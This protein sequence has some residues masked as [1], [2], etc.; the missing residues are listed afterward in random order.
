MILLF[1]ACTS[2]KPGARDSL[3]A[4]DSAPTE[5]TGAVDTAITG[6]DEA[7][8]LYDRS[9]LHEISI[10]LADADWAELRAQSRSYYSLLGE[11]CGE[12]PW[13]SPY[14]WFLGEV[15]V[16]GTDLGTVGVRKK[17]LIGS[18]SSERPSLKIDVDHEVDDARYLG[19][20]KLTLNNNNQDPGRLRTCLAHDLF[21]DAGLVAPRCSLAH[22]TVNGEDL[23]VYSNTENID[24]DLVARRRGALPSAMYEGALSDFREDWLVTFEAET[25]ESDGH[26]LVP[27][28]EALEAPD[29]ELLARLDEVIDLE[30]FFTFWAAESLAGH[31]DGYNGNTNNF[32]V[33]V[34][35][36]DGRLEFIASGPDAAFDARRPFGSDQPNWV[37]TTSALANRLIQHDEGKAAYE[38]ELQRLLDEV[39]DADGRLAELDAFAELVSGLDTRAQREGIADTRTVIEHR[40]ADIEDD[41]GERVSPAEL[42]GAYCWVEVGHASVVFSTTWGS[43]PSGDLFTGG[44][45]ETDYVF[46]EVT[47]TSTADGV[48]AGWAEDG[49][50]LWLTISEL[51]P[52]T[53][54]APYVVFDPDL[55]AS[56]AEITLDGVS[57]EG[58]ILYNA[59]TTGGEWQTVA[60]LGNGSLRFDEAGDGRGDVLSGV[61]DAAVLGS[62]E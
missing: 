33:Y 24:E 10:T 14:T 7:D 30:A 12:G 8:P 44:E 5:D 28:V 52:D 43:Y 51:A 42:R 19:L 55:L 9:V 29:E 13:E 34:A 39:W 15:A 18:Q 48:S 47:Y 22:V 35:P 31:W 26:E 11:G 4:L 58:A 3:V 53:Y 56:G 59:S 45:A 57:A 46:S 16:D 54:L 23:G 21:A 27:V 62:P 1:L 6:G 36:E 40:A 25:D 37:A 61:L 20:E 17:G 49:R 32:Y 50:A 60:Y 2:P 41:L 38:A